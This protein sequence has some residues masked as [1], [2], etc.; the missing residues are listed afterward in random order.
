MVEHFK[1]IFN[2]EMDTEIRE[3]RKRSKE[4]FLQKLQEV[5]W[6]INS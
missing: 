1:R 5:T 2:V 6:T 4:E 3:W